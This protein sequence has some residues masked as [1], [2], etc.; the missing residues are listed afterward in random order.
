[1]E[2]SAL[3]LGMLFGSLMLIAV[4]WVY[5]K[6]QIFGLGGTTLTLFGVL[7]LG[8]SIFKTVKIS[9]S[10]GGKIEAKFQAI[11]T[12]VNAVARRRYR[13]DKSPIESM[14]GNDG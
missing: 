14:A 2:T 12:R 4:A 3:V 1:M 5:I 11:N 13:N 9:V 10:P 7:F 8:L 6:H